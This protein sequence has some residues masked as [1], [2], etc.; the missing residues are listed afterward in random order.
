MT[1]TTVTD[2]A[3][4][5]TLLRRPTRRRPRPR[6]ASAAQIGTPPTTPS[7]AV[8]DGLLAPS[9]PGVS[10][11]VTGVTKL[12]SEVARARSTRAGARPTARPASSA[13]ARS[14]VTRSPPGRS[15]TGSPASSA[16]WPRSTCSSA[17]STCCRCCRWTAG[18][19]RSCGSRA[20]A[21][22]WPR[23]FHRKDPGRVDIVKLTPALYAVL[24][25]DRRVVRHLARGGYREPD[26]QPVLRMPR[27]VAMTAVSLGLPAV[28]PRVAAARAS[29][30]RS[31]SARCRSA[32][33]RRCRSS[34]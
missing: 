25:L 14:P 15:P 16:S 29:P 7:R 20:S 24:I 6:S 13:S 34:R 17:C 4:G 9:A 2:P 10:Q 12:P 26:R 3:T 5:K 30:G 11:T 21:A 1:P 32:A 28:P 23:C 18:T 19:S 31:R 22:G 33:T 27:E 8:P